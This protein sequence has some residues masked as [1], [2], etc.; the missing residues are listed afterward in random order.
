MPFKGFYFLSGLHV[1]NFDF[2]RTA[3]AKEFSIRTES[4]GPYP[5]GM[6]LKGFHMSLATEGTLKLTTIAKQPGERMAG[7]FEVTSGSAGTSSINL[8]GVFDFRVPEGA[9]EDCKK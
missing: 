6:P 1:P 3:R 7:G 9:W 5:P 2:L 8:E 4:D